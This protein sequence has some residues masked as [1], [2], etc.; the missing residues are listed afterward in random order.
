MFNKFTTSVKKFFNFWK[1]RSKANVGEAVNMAREYL[2]VYYKIGHPRVNYPPFRVRHPFLRL[3][4]IHDII[5]TPR[6]S[7]H[8]T[9]FYGV[10]KRKTASGLDKFAVVIYDR[11]RGKYVNGGSYS[12]IMTA[13][14]VATY[15]VEKLYHEER[16][17]LNDSL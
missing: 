10:V 8:S 9:P 15:I 2:Q 5:V 17:Y 7:V 16:E 4:R 12:N 6:E 11:M 13:G 1:P 14:Y 3:K